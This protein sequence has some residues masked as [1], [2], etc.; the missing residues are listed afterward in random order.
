MTPPL[1][2]AD[3]ITILRAK[4]PDALICTAC[5]LLLATQR[6]SYAKSNPTEEQRLAYVCAECRQEQ[7]EA[8]RIAQARREALA[9]ARAV[10]AEKRAERADMANYP[11]PMSKA[12]ADPHEQRG[13]YAVADGADGAIGKADVHAGVV[14]RA[15]LVVR[16]GG[17]D[18]G[19][20][21]GGG[22]GGSLWITAGTLAGT[23][24]SGTDSVPA[25]SATWCGSASRRAANT[26]PRNRATANRPIRIA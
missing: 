5:G 7:A 15:E 11:A 2:I 25:T 21:N 16:D 12:S 6:A 18:G 1:S 20:Y 14:R 13:V 3:T 4:Y 22:S 23:G 8:E 10:Q 9:L 19:N 26:V 24:T 17:Q